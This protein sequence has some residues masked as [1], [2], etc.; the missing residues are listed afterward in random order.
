M[1]YQW[2]KVGRS[3]EQSFSRKGAGGLLIGTYSQKLDEK[4]RLNFPV[5]FR[6]EMGD[7][8][9]V[10]CWLD[11]CLIALPAARFEQIF[12]RLTESGMVKNRGLRRMLYAGAVE[13]VP[14]KQGRILL[15]PPLREHAGLDKEV[16]VI[17]VGDCVELWDPA[18]WKAM[19]DSMRSGDS[20]AAMEELDL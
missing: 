17:G 6:D 14:D 8:F 13:A 3:G 5:R 16:V 10:T 12:A 1:L 15:P 2:V 11:E 7:Q 20:A 19:Q 9:Y 18:R 4:G